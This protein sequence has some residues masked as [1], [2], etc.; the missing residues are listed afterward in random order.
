MGP[1]MRL[2]VVNLCACAFALR[3]DGNSESSGA[4]PRLSSTRAPAARRGA[5][6]QARRRRRGIAARARDVRTALKGGGT[7][8]PLG[9]H[10]KETSGGGGLAVSAMDTGHGR[11]MGPD[12]LPC[13]PGDRA[14]SGCGSGTGR[15]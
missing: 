14:W 2:D 11:G 1:W 3:V 10:A 12:G 8:G 4:H 5:S 6:G 9:A 13:G 7:R 15:R